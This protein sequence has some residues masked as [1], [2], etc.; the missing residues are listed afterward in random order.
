MCGSMQKSMNNS[1]EIKNELNEGST[2][3]KARGGG[4]IGWKERLEMTARVVV[5]GS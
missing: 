3:E 2:K 1:L 4:R 5:G